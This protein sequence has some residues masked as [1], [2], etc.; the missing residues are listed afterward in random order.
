MVP[1][2]RHVLAVSLMC[3]LYLTHSKISAN[4]PSPY[5]LT[6][7]ITQAI[8]SDAVIVDSATNSSHIAILDSYYVLRV[9]SFSSSGGFTLTRQ[10]DTSSWF[11]NSGSAWSHSRFTNTGAVAVHPQTGEVFIAAYYPESY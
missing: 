10:R 2:W 3:C 8:P 5:Y 4:I 6:L 9:Y 11:P 7:P 1:F